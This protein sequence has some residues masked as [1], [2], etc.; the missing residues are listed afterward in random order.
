MRPLLVGESNPYSRNPGDALLPWPEG[1]A[2]ARLRDILGMTNEVYLAAF[3]RVNLLGGSTKWSVRLARAVV[4]GLPD[5]D[6]ILLGARVCA[7]HGVGFVPFTC[8][9]PDGFRGGGA[10]DVHWLILP[11]PSGRCR[12]WNEGTAARA[13]DVVARFVSGECV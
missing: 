4:S 11:H 13:R 6:R 10:A 3:D 2:G 12:L 8:V 1:A 5:V 7:A 9:R